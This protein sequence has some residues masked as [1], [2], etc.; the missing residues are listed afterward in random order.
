[1]AGLLVIHIAAA[2]AILMVTT[3]Y[4]TRQGG[5]P[6]IGF[7]IGMAIFSRFDMTERDH[8]KIRAEIDA[9]RSDIMAR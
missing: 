5:L 8:A 7:A 1:M 4:I 6:L 3:L 9:R 2:L